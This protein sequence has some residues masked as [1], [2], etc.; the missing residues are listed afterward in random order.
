MRRLGYLTWCVLIVSAAV[1]LALQVPAIHA[2]SA[3]SPPGNVGE[4]PDFATCVDCH[5]SFALDS[6]DGE[7]SI[8]FPGG[9][10]SGYQPDS[11]YTFHVEIED[12]GLE[13]W[14]FQ[15]TALDDCYDFAGDLEPGNPD[16]SKVTVADEKEYITHTRTGTWAGVPDGPVTWRMEWTA[17]PAGTGPVT[18]FFTGNA[19]DND[20]KSQGDYVYS[21]TMTLDELDAV[22]G[23]EVSLLGVPQSIERGNTL[24][25]VAKVSNTGSV[26][27]GFDE[28]DLDAYGPYPHYNTSLYNGPTITLSPGNDVSAPISLFIPPVTPTGDYLVEISISKNSNLVDEACFYID[29]LP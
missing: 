17:P 1:I 26:D 7:L 22:G 5:N 11:L 12:F 18:F 20:L 6:G 9:D 24:Q 3:G 19:A 29:V 21:R 25:F 13:R 10:P 16:S 28:A 14:G 23:L 2:K 4:P 15:L 27:A 8:E